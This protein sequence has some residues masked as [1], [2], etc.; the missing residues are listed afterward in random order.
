[1]PRAP[2]AGL[3]GDP[4]EGNGMINVSF[5]FFPPGDAA[6]EATLWRSVER[7]RPLAPKFV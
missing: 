3:H 1:M 6:M 2:E 5:E 7:L 4:D